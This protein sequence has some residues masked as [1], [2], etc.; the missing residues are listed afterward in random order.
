MNYIVLA[1][2]EVT[3][4]SQT[5]P[6]ETWMDATPGGS[7]IHVRPGRRLSDGYLFKSADSC[8][9]RSYMHPEYEYA[10]EPGYLVRPVIV[11]EEP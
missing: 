5:R 9:Y 10:L 4:I 1:V 2:A 3:T 8:R 11:T 7:G 6:G